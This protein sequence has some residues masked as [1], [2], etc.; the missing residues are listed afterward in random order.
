MIAEPESMQP[1]ADAP[2]HEVPNDVFTV[3]LAAAQHLVFTFI[4]GLVASIGRRVIGS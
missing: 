4:G 3:A 1:S 2:L